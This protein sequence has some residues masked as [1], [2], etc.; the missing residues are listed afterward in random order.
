MI[1]A[2]AGHVDHGKT[3]LIR[4][5]TSVETD[6][7]PEEKA[8]GI[9]IDIGFA[10]WT[11][12]NAQVVG[13]V[14]V[15]GHERFVRNMLAG[16]CG[17]DYVML[18]V[19]ADDGVMP[20]TIEHFQIVDLLG[21]RRGIAVITKTDRVSAERVAEV[22]LEIRTLLSGSP[23]ADVA[24]MPISAQYGQGVE[25]L[26]DHITNDALQ[27]QAARDTGRAFRFVIDRAFTVAGSG[28]VVTGTVFDGEVHVGDRLTL[29]PSGIEARVRAVQ[30]AGM[31]RTGAT[32]GERAAL[33]LAGVAV[34]QVARG[35][36]LLQLHAPTQRIDVRLRLLDDRVGHASRKALSHGAR[37]HLHIGAADVTAR[38]AMPRGESIAADNRSPL[39]QLVLDRPVA[40]ANGDRFILRDHSATRTIGGGVVVDPQAPRRRGEPARRIAQLRAL[41]RF[42]AAHSLPALLEASPGG[43]AL[44]YFQRV[45]NLAEGALNDL[46][47]Q[48]D[49]VV[50]GRSSAVVLQRTSIESIRRSVADMLARFHRDRPQTPGMPIA[51]L[52]RACAPAL[53]GNSFAELMRRFASDRLLEIGGS[54]ARLATHVSTANRNDEITWQRIRPWLHDASFKGMTVDAIAVQSGIGETTLLSF[55]NRK[56][57]TGEVVRVSAERFYPREVMAQLAQLALDTASASPDGQF[58]AAKYRDAVGVNRMHAIELLECLDRLHI[59]RRIGDIRQMRQDYEPLFGPAAPLPTASVKRMSP[60]PSSTNL[61]GS[62][63]TS[64]DAKQTTAFRRH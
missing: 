34:D 25:A 17:V 49:L 8:R 29:S 59:T 35:D 55:L 38:L 41:E 43:V 12:D 11:L 2:T 46:L 10:Y 27:H 30:Q 54:T 7:L 44:H 42:D 20:Q 37:V 4:A 52:G 47:Q 51:E 57:S 40:V 32:F 36:W 48:F 50:V 5:L 31:P 13:F 24:V 18:V 64:R 6:R 61:H 21:V 16:V 62:R 45:F 22:E 14:D 60:P 63:S 3:T 53:D 15:P 19:A 28:T 56:A 9:S 58:T 33:N 39:A 23:L 26:R 1:V